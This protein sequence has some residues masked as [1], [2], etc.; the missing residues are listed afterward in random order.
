M[1]SMKSASSTRAEKAPRSASSTGAKKVLS[2]W[3]ARLSSGCWKSDAERPGMRVGSGAAT[4]CM[5]MNWETR[6]AIGR[7][8]LVV[9]CAV[10]NNGKRDAAVAV[11][12]L[13]F[14]QS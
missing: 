5:E 11:I 14:A 10:A 6:G 1:L 3:L 7:L 13:T 2:S 12:A 4:D 9:T 8:G